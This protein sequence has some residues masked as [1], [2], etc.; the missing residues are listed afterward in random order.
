MKAILF[1]KLLWIIDIDLFNH[2]CKNIRN[3]SIF[4]KI[5]GHG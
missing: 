3:I 4:A 2:K 5:S 1:K